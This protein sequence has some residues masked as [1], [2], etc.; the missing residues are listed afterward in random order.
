MANDDTKIT[1]TFE[2]DTSPVEKGFK[3]VATIAEK[4]AKT[5]SNSEKQSTNSQKQAARIADRTRDKSKLSQKVQKQLDQFVKIMKPRLYSQELRHHAKVLRYKKEEERSTVKTVKTQ[6]S[7]MQKVRTWRTSRAGRESTST[8]ILGPGNA[9][10]GGGS[11]GGSSRRWW[12]RRRPHQVDP[13]NVKFQ[14]QNNSR[15]GTFFDEIGGVAMEALSAALGG[16]VSLFKKQLGTAI[17]SYEQQGRAG[18][19]LEGMGSLA[20]VNNPLQVARSQRMGYSLTESYGHAATVGRQTG[21]VG[22]TATAQE[23]SRI[24]GGSVEEVGGVMGQLTRGGSKFNSTGGGSGRRQ[25]AKMFQDAVSSGLDASRT[26]EHLEA[27]GSLAEFAGS[28]SSRNVDFGQISGM[29]G[30]LGSTGRSGFQGARGASFLSG[31]DQGIRSGG[32]DDSS[33]AIGLQAMGFGYGGPNDVSYYEA[34]KML[35]QGITGEGGADRL[36]RIMRTMMAATGGGEELYNSLKTSGFMGDAT[37]QQIED[38]VNDYQSK[39]RT[40]R[41]TQDLIE[42]FQGGSQGSIAGR[43]QAAG[44]S[45]NLRVNRQDARLDNRSAEQGSQLY[46]SFSDMQNLLNEM[47]DMAMPK[48]IDGLNGFADMI[49]SIQKENGWV[50]RVSSQDSAVNSRNRADVMNIEDEILAASNLSPEKQ[51]AVYQ[52]A[53]EKLTAEMAEQ[54]GI[55]STSSAGETQSRE[56]YSAASDLRERT[57]R[58]IRDLDPNATRP[59]TL[60]EAIA[61][62]QQQITEVATQIGAAIVEAIRQNAQQNTFTVSRNPGPVDRVRNSNTQPGT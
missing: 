48:V 29:L 19:R 28:R 52:Q 15:S 34:E 50:G 12:Q 44:T 45:T 32:V 2:A 36:D 26:G 21:Q 5:Q 24:Y 16:T 25:M 59:P 3:T 22:A 38:F 30:L 35:E 1:V 61:Q 27:V 60:P 58:R 46:D 37:R 8:N 55:Q 33:K 17:S 42:R 62:N 4:V 56:I 18:A 13:S 23:F 47:V 39:H 49:K 20:G 10:G 6:L 31:I 54:R 14:N 53:V 43:I 11:G 41:S 7:L 40:G 57:I 51:V 9:G